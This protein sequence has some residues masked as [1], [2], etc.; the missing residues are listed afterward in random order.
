[1]TF[2]NQHKILGEDNESLAEVSKQKEVKVKSPT[3]IDILSEILLSLRK[4]EFHLSIG[5]DTDLTNTDL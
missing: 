2:I 4:I 5:S 3:T 1:M